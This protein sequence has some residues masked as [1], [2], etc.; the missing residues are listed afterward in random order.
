MFFIFSSKSARLYSFSLHNPVFGM[1]PW[2]W[3]ESWAWLQGHF[4]RPLA[5]GE[6]VSFVL[7]SGQK[8]VGLDLPSSLSLF[9]SS[10]YSNVWST[11]YPAYK[12]TL[13]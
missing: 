11:F 1:A 3:E 9:V 7:Q 12:S 10:T 2:L 4:S 8:D 13:V 5:K 6:A